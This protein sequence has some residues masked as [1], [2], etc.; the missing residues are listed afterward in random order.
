M[1]YIR[2]GVDEPLVRLNLKRLDPDKAGENRTETNPIIG[3]G[4]FISMPYMVTANP[5]AHERYLQDKLFTVIRFE[6]DSRV[7]LDVDGQE[8]TIT[9]QQP[10]VCD[11]GDEQIQVSIV[12][13]TSRS[14]LH[15]AEHHRQNG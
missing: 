14:V 7:V 13:F 15:E 8:M 1:N 6:T 4:R 2:E 5:G 3:I 9:P 12:E 10:I 11:H